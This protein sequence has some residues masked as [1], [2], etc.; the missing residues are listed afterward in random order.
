MSVI[1]GILIGLFVIALLGILTGVLIVRALYRSI[2]RNRAVTGAVLRTRAAFTWGPQQQVLKLRLRLGASLES[3]RAAVELALRSD[4]PRGELVRLF[5]RIQAE[6]A[7]LDSQLRLLESETDSG[8]LAAEVPLVRDRVEQLEALVRRLRS[9][10]ASGLAGISDDT[11]AAL[12]ADVDREVAA[13]HAGVQELHT[14]NSF[15]G[16]QEPRRQTSNRLYR[17]NES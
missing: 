6:G 17:G 16:R 9:A 11:L 8:V 10:V 14:L 4:G 13:L 7:T 3:G 15:D 1:A 5:K 2:R 12:R